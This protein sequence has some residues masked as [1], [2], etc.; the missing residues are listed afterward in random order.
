MYNYKEFLIRTFFILLSLYVID[1]IEWE[2]KWKKIREA[3]AK[4]FDYLMNEFMNA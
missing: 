3:S 1:E 4:E 2:L